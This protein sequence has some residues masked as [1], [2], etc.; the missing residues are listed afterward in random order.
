[1]CIG[2]FSFF[3]GSIG[4]LKGKSETAAVTIQLYNILFVLKINFFFF[5]KRLVKFF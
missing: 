3:L 5:A 1:M 4:L 2:R